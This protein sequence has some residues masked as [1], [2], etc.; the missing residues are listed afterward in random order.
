MG[1]ELFGFH[2]DKRWDY[3]NGF[4]LTSHVTH[5]AKMLA[6]FELYKSITGLPGHVV[7][8]G[9]FKGVSLIRF[10]TFREVLESQY[11]RKIVGFDAF[12]KFPPPEDMLDTDF[13]ERFEKVAGDGIPIDELTKVLQH[14]AFSNVELIPGDI[15][16]TVPRYIQE[17]PELRIALLHIDVDVYKPSIVILNHFYDKIVAGGLVVFDDFGTVAG[18]TRAVDEF[19]YGKGVTLRKLS[20]SDMPVYIRK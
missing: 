8:C 2:T 17:H 16:S 9:V 18:E 20:I 5:T 7:E 4:Y 12:G 15:L 13:V 3:E 19:F 6:H 1:K 14:K 11:S 10:A